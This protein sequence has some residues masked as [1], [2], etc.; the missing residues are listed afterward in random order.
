MPIDAIAAPAGSGMYAAQPSRAPKQEIDSEVFMSLLVTQLQ[1]QDPGSPMDTNA[2]IGQTTQLAM[3]EKL[4][5]LS[6]Q[7]EEAFGLQMRAA[8]AALI[9]Q[10]V[11]Y[12]GSNGEALTGRA[13]SVSFENAVP[14]VKIGGVSIAL[15]EISGLS[16]Q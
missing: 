12:T 15:D 8:A 3:M 5:E 2:M 11:S 4:T 1:H 9:G 16:A 6:A 7:G 13:E 10:Q 14:Q